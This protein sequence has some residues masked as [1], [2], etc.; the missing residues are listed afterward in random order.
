MARRVRRTSG[1]LDAPRTGDPAGRH[2]GIRHDRDPG[3]HPGARRALPPRRVSATVRNILAELEIDGLLTHP[4]T[5]A[6]RIPTDAGYRFFVES[7]VEQTAAAAGRA[8]DDPPP[9]RAGR[10]RQRALVPPGRDDAR[11][12]DPRRRPRHAR[13]SRAPHASAGSTSSR[14]TSGWPASILVLREGSIKQ[15]LMTLDAATTDGELDEAAHRLNRTCVGLAAADL[16]ERLRWFED[17]PADDP[18]FSTRPTRR[19]ASA[20]PPPR[21]RRD[22]RRGGLQRRAAQRHGGA[23]VRR[24]ATSCGGSSPPSRTGRTW[25]SSSEDVA[26]PGELHVF[27]GH[28]NRPWRCATSPSSSRRTAGRGPPSASS[29]SSVRPGCRYSQAIGTVRFVSGLMNE[30]VD[31]LYS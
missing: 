13:P 9:V 2:R 18:A 24:R 25:A 6:G 11:L 29:A 28:E 17:A 12:G 21:L 16:V 3:R 4:H 22:H 30:L 31:H 20:P 19:R 14:S 1:P 23:R 27:I 10:V 5:S 26:G 8:A 15:A 7:I